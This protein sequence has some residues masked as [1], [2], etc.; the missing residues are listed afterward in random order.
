MRFKNTKEFWKYQ[1]RNVV[2]HDNKMNIIE[3][4]IDRHAKATPNRLA[5]VFD[6]GKKIKKYT[7]KQLEEEVN[8]FAN[9]LNNLNVKKNSHI[10]LFLPKCPEMYIGFLGAIKHGSIAIPLFEAF[11]KDG[12]ELRL[13]RGDANIV[14]TNKDLS[15]RLAKDIRKKVPTLKQII[16]VDSKKYK[17]QIKKQ[18]PKFEAVRRKLKDTALMIFTSSTAGT[19]V[20]GIQI[21][22]YGLVQQHFT[23]EL[24]LKLVPES[25]Y[26]CTAHPGWVTGA[27]YGII[28]P[29]SIGCTNYVIESHFDAKVWIDFIKKNKID[30]L[31]T[32][33]TALRLLKPELKKSDLIGIKNIASVGEALT[34]ATFEHYKALGIEI[35]DTYWQTE[36][37]AM[38]IAAYDKKKAGSMGKAIPGIK[39]KLINGEIAAKP[40]WPAIMTG[41]YKH[42]K[43][44]RSYFKNGWFKT[45]DMVTKKAGL[46]YFKNRHDDIIKTSGER[47]SPIEIESILMKDKSVKEAAVIG[48]PD[49]IKGSILKAFIVLNK[50]FDPSD[51]LKEL[52]TMHV[53]KN[54]A[55]HAYPKQ[56]EFIKEL[57]KTNSGKIIRMK[58]REIEMKK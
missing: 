36:T 54:Y 51:K 56:I 58:L 7:Y 46:F 32:A 48:I 50:G 18:S 25:H 44:Y 55:G 28:A 41:I 43:M 5:F 40:D 2:I 31:Y 27:V 15:K 26:L 35:T 13:E 11:Q 53:K 45:N 12:V 52:L 19:P 14:I 49:P 23:A 6:D 21:P 47:V 9:L 38:I 16:I 1:E 37:G 17:S 34:S 20:A 39:I 22:H 4:C 3:T 42:P 57:P 10:F 33:P 8:K 29:L 24:V 30:I